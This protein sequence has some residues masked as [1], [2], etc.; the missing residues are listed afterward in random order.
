M[1]AKARSRCPTESARESEPER[2]GAAPHPL[3]FA[4]PGRPSTPGDPSS[5]STLADPSMS[6]FLLMIGGQL[7][8]ARASRSALCRRGSI[9]VPWSTWSSAA[10]RTALRPGRLQHS[11]LS[12]GAPRQTSAGVSTKQARAAACL[13]A[14]RTRRR[15]RA[16]MCAHTAPGRGDEA[17]GSAGRLCRSD[18]CML[19]AV[20][21]WSAREMYSSPGLRSGIGFCAERYMPRDVG[22][23]Y[24]G[25]RGAGG[26]GGRAQTAARVSPRPRPADPARTH[27]ARGGG[28][29]R[30]GAQAPPA[31]AHSR[32]T[33][34]AAWSRPP[35]PG[36]VRHRARRVLVR[37][38][39]SPHRPSQDP[40]SHWPGRL[41]AHT[42]R[43][44]V[45]RTLPLVD[46][47]FLTVAC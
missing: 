34:A 3:M 2:V 39:A 28:G 8:A 46:S 35:A 25:W 27:G 5:A 38:R 41:P 47:T 32:R 19:S 7:W 30:P 44:G 14:T 4:C 24:C 15:A 40:R 18:I 31:L 23:R 21:P 17:P 22:R 29:R 45:S 16:C 43:C 33:A 26:G 36:E 10:S 13:S 42:A 11:T 6:A 12:R 20:R 1:S 9:P 37:S